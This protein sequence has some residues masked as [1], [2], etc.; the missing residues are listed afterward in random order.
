M[1]ASVLAL[2]ERELGGAL[3]AGL[4]AFLCATSSD[5][6]AAIRNCVASAKDDLEP[7]ARAHVPDGWIPLAGMS[8][9][10][11]DGHSMDLIAELGRESDRVVAWNWKAE[12]PDAADFDELA[13][14]YDGPR[15]E[16]GGFAHLLWWRFGDRRLLFGSDRKVPASVA[17]MMR[18]VRN[19]GLDLSGPAVDGFSVQVGA[20]SSARV[21]HAKF[22]PGEIV[23]ELDGDKVEIRFE[24][25]SVRRLMRRFVQPA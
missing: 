16:V 25:G 23:E 8:T 6:T 21:M 13:E 12:P 3:P 24:D 19:P 11:G 15:F 17:P 9:K 10:E 22:G 4:L 7:D 20:P 2:A 14:L 18:A 5:P 1:S